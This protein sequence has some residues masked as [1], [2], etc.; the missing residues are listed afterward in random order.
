MGGGGL[1]GTPHT[2][3]IV[4]VVVVVVVFLPFLCHVCVF[5]EVGE[6]EAEAQGHVLLHHSETEI[7]WPW[8]RK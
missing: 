7:I 2:V 6:G 4:V 8:G 3:V 1:G 5:V